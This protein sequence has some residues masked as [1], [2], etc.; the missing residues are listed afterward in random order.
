MTAA[1]API[2]P[3][4]QRRWWGLVALVCGVQIGLIFWLGERTPRGPRPSAPAPS[5]CLVGLARAP[6][7]ALEDPTLFVLP[8]REGFSSLA[9]LQAPPQQFQPP[10]WH[11]DPRWLRLSFGQLGAAIN[12]LL[13]TNVLGPMPAAEQPNPA[14]T[15]PKLVRP[16]SFPEHSTVR[17]RGALAQRRL[18]TQLQTPS[19]TSAELLKPTIVQVVVDAEGQPISAVLLQ[20]SGSPDADQTALEQ[21][22]AARFATISES[23]P[24]RT[25]SPLAG[26]T[27]GEMVFAWH[28][29]PLPPINTDTNTPA[30]PSAVDQNN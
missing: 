29:L 6:M 22:R 14:P 12:Q 15:L 23:G 10:D 25:T 19:P 24:G 13:A 8:H 20:R 3:W 16:E 2:Q 28:T 18:L 21:A 27:W 7:L 9:W 30:N 11:E 1:S 4:S 5:L 26:L 17:V